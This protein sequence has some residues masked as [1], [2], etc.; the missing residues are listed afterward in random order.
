MSGKILRKFRMLMISVTRYFA[1]C[2]SDGY[3]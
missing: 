1:N 3:L 2:I